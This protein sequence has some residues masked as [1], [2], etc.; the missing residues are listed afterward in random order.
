I[1]AATVAV[2]QRKDGEFEI[3][4]SHVPWDR[5]YRD[6][7]SR[8]RDF[9]DASF[10]GVVLWMDE[11]EALSK[12]EG[13]DEQIKGSYSTSDDGADTYDDRPKLK[14]ADPQRKRIRVLQH[15]WVE[16]GVWHTAILCRGGFL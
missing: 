11:A 6:P 10:L 16:D 1:G 2:K 9:S 14:W 13:R 12:F 4:L 3:T 5:F 8:R 15:R 7:H